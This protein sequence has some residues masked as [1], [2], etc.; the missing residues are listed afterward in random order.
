MLY[1]PLHYSLVMI[2]C[3][4]SRINALWG[5]PDLVHGIEGGMENDST[6]SLNYL[7][8]MVRGSESKLDSTW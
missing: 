8:Y 1:Y 4:A 7:G 2:I 6:S 3:R 5:F